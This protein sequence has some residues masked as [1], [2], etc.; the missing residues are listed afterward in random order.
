[1]QLFFIIMK[2][3]RK[4]LYLYTSVKYIIYLCLFLE[5]SNDMNRYL[6]KEMFL[7]YSWSG[8]LSFSSEILIQFN[9]FSLYA[10]YTS[11][12]GLVL[13]IQRWIRHN[14]H[15]QVAH[16]YMDWFASS[17]RDFSPS[18]GWLVVFSNCIS[19]SCHI[20]KIL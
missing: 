15:P 8:N 12:P 7:F 10:F 16:N 13:I 17:I 9:K 6:F 20:S 14:R 11:S 1:M 19:S 18:F 4:Y 5:C 3:N 2:I